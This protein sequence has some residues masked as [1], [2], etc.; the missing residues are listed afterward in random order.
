MVG[1]PAQVGGGR[2]AEGRSTAGDRRRS[3]RSCLSVEGD[4]RMRALRRS[5]PHCAAVTVLAVVRTRATEK[6]LRALNARKGSPGGWVKSSTRGAKDGPSIRTGNLR[7]YGAMRGSEGSRM[8]LLCLRSTLFPWNP[9]EGQQ[10]GFWC[11]VWTRE[12]GSVGK[13]RVVV[14]LV[15]GEGGRGNETEQDNEQCRDSQ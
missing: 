14:K 3:R 11:L 2:R 4:Q 13:K 5:N 9:V 6:L 1:R 10:V 8:G 15:F 7:K 12:A